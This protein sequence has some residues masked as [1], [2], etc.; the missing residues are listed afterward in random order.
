M[1]QDA[2]KGEKMN[3]K[4][5]NSLKDKM[6]GLEWMEQQ[7]QSGTE[8]VVIGLT[9]NGDIGV[10]T[11]AYDQA[12]PVGTGD[13][14]LE[15]LQ[16]AADRT[17]NTETSSDPRRT[18]EQQVLEAIRLRLVAIYHTC[19]SSAAFKRDYAIRCGDEHEATACR[20]EAC[21]YEAAAGW[22]DAA[23]NNFPNKSMSVGGTA[24]GTP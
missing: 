22:I 24:V 2:G 20:R 17:A 3:Q 23:L 15:A 19:M 14:A 8:A 18:E 12:P 4:D 13:T 7:A 5:A 16:D 9:E 6:T 21:G 10:W 1:W 11:N